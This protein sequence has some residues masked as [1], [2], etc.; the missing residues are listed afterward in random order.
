MGGTMLG[1]FI[2]TTA[3][4]LAIR[5]LLILNIDNNYAISKDIRETMGTYKKMFRF[6]IYKIKNRRTG[7]NLSFKQWLRKEKA[8]GNKEI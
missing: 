6:L 5:R 4:I 2:G 1:L 8:L 7:P 3:F